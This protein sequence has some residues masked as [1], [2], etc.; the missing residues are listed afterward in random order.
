MHLME[1]LA[2]TRA[3]LAKVAAARQDFDLSSEIQM[4]GNTATLLSD[5]E[6]ELKDFERG[7][8]RLV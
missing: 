3:G 7:I 8:E 1:A 2:A 4:P 5:T 6:R